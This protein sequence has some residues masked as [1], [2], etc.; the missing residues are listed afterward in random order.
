MSVILFRKCSKFNVDLRNEEK[1]S[2]KVFSFSDNSISN[3]CVNL[4]LLRRE[5]LPSG[6]NVLTNSLNILHSTKI[7]FF[8][9]NYVHSDQ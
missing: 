6:V 5:Y 2:E 3:G 1:N 7:D 9:M 8:Q 4:S